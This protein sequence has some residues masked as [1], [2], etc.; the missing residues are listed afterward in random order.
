VLLTETRGGD[1]ALDRMP[2]DVVARC[3]AAWAALPPVE[4]CVVHGD[5]GTG[6]VV[7]TTSAVGLLDWD[8][9]R[10]DDPRFDLGALPDAA[11]VGATPAVRRA[12]LAWD[13]ATCWVAEPAYARR[14]LAAL[15]AR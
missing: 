1:I 5:P 4:A 11:G 14:R 7:L 3:R 6:N 8:E 2:A 15:E 9:A 10:V 12:A 13:V